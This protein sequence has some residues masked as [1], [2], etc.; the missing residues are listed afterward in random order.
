M[1]RI[2]EVFIVLAVLTLFACNSAEN[3]STDIGGVAANEA[4]DKDVLVI[5][6]DD[7]PPQL[8]PH[9]SSAA[10]D[11]Q[12]FQS[13]YNKLLDIDENLEFVGEL[14][15]DWDISE[16]GLTYTFYLEED[17]V[18][19]DGTPFNAEAVKFNFDRMLDP[20]FSSPRASEVNLLE[21]IVIINDYEVDLVL[22]EPFAPFLSV[23]TDRAGMM[24]SPTAVEELGNDFANQP[25]GTGPYKF[26]SRVS[27]SKIELSR[28]EDYWDELPAFEKV[29]IRPFADSNVRVTNLVSGDLDMLNKIA[30]KDIEILSNDPN[31]TLLEQDGIGFQGIHLNTT[32]EPFTQKEVRKA[33]NL[34]IDR[35]AI[36]NVVFHGGAIPSVSPFPPISWAAPEFEQPNANVE[37]AKKLLEEAGVSDVSFTLKINPRPEEEQMAQMIQQMLSEIGMTMNIEMVEFGTMLDQLESGDFQAV[38]LGWSGRIDPDG[39]AYRFFYSNASNNYSNFANPTMDKLLDEARTTVDVEARKEIYEEI[40]DLLWEESPYVFVYHEQDYKAMKNYVKGFRH[41]ADQMIR[42]NSIYFE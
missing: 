10:V 26:D 30:F 3:T 40:S 35:E 32:V 41:I 17:V 1:K 25:V 5:G 31:I 2:L 22:S 15:K 27:Q 11:R 28:F 20:S 8:D 37:E 42:T 13:L 38:R 29:E 18:F 21:E 14:A 23:L 33:I 34:A 9:R 4:T 16:D 6:L 39:N 24:V 12:T 36:T 19:H 7:D